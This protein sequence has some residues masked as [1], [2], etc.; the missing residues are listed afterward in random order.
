MPDKKQI[1]KSIASIAKE[2]GHAP[3]KV[4]FQSRSGISQFF[5]LQSFRSWTEAVRTA[6][7]EPYT[8][9]AKIEDRAL[10]EDW[11]KVVRRNRGVPPRH[12]YWRDGK[13][14]PVTLQKRFGGYSRMPEAF[15]NFAKGKRKW[16]DVVALLPAPRAQSKEPKKSRSYPT[17]PTKYQSLTCVKNA[18]RCH[19]AQP[20]LAR[21]THHAQLKDRPMCGNPMDF[22]GLRHEP[23]NEQG[24]VLLFGML[25]K[26][27]GYLIEAAQK[28]F[29][30]CEAKRE[31]AP[32]RWQRVNIEFE[33]ESKN[34]REHGHPLNGCDV[35]VCWRHNW[36]ACP[37]HIEVLELSSV[38]KSNSLPVTYEL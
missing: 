31:I 4:E 7:V 5:V 14:N 36:G 25:A 6:G 12:I 23:V 9:N 8:R 30:D 13:Y 10:L 38:V 26:E 35:I 33:Y 21:G 27:L 11:G 20:L 1:L 3:S 24:V 22:R 19:S 15:R 16:R 17:L 28:G 34:F 32:G 29:P 2:L 37:K 18:K